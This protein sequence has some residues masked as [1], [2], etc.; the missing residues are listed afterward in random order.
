[1]R[2]SWPEI[3]ILSLA[4]TFGLSGLAGGQTAS[5][6]IGYNV[7]EFEVAGPGVEG[8]G[9]GFMDYAMVTLQQEACSDGDNSYEIVET[10]NPR[11]MAA[12]EAEIELQQDPAFDPATRITPRWIQWTHIVRGSLQYGPSGW[13]ADLRVED[14]SGRVVARVAKTTPGSDGAL[15]ALDRAALALSDQLCGRS[16]GAWVGT[17]DV[18]VNAQLE[19]GWSSVS[20]VNCTMK[21]SDAGMATCNVTTHGAIQGEDHTMVRQGGGSVRVKIGVRGDENSTTI[22]FGSFSYKETTAVTVTQWTEDGPGP[23]LSNTTEEEKQDGGWDFTGASPGSTSEHRVGQWKSPDG[24][25]TA[26][27]DLTYD[28]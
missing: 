16:R 28:H 1:M 27:W 7:D 10:A 14:R 2:K 12:L 8:T 6:E 13:T 24:F 4:M 26:T 25:T 21:R 23:T 22:Q 5:M 19:E 15:D 20:R 18:E 3:A 11:C 9:R 17:V